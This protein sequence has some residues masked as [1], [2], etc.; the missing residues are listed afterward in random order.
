MMAPETSFFIPGE[1]AVS[2]ENKS[3]KG[4]AKADQSGLLKLLILLLVGMMGIFA[5]II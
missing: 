4:Y 5:L 2:K 3:S 1:S